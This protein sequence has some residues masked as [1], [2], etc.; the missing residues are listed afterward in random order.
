MSGRWE[1]CNEKP[2]KQDE[3]VRMTWDKKMI[4][5]YKVWCLQKMINCKKDKSF[6]QPEVTK[7]R[8]IRHITY[9]N[10]Q[11]WNERRDMRENSARSLLEDFLE[12]FQKTSWKTSWKSSSALNVRRLSRRLPWKPSTFVSDLKKSQ[13]WKTCI[14]K[15]FKWLQ[16]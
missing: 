11:I 2:T 7:S 15:A 8:K 9:Q 1:P 16:I 6:K 10:T 3:L 13:I 12:D 4:N 14:P 5:W